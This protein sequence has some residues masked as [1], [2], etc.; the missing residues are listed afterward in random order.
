MENDTY[1]QF[2]DFLEIK[3]K[4]LKNDLPKL[5]ISNLKDKIIE[6]RNYLET[7]PKYLQGIAPEHIM[8]INEVIEYLKE[9]ILQRQ[10]N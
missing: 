2:F 7:P 8:L 9:E 6:W 5:S 4:E 1:E 10:A 3:C